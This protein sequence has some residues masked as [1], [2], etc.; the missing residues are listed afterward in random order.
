MHNESRRLLRYPP[1]TRSERAA[2][3]DHSS[4]HP[5]SESAKATTRRIADKLQIS[6]LSRPLALQWL[7]AI[8]DV[9]FEPSTEQNVRHAFEQLVSSEAPSTVLPAT[10]DPAHDTGR[11]PMRAG[12]SASVQRAKGLRTVARTARRRMDTRKRKR[13]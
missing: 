4:P 1:S 6:A 11:A 10:S 9:L 2:S 12:A 5:P 7:E 3:P 8:I 13:R